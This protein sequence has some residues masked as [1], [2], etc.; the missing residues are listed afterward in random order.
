MPVF[1]L[2]IPQ[3]KQD[4]QKAKLWQ[5]SYLQQGVKQ[6]EAESKGHVYSAFKFYL[7]QHIFQNV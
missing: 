4:R 2:G 3:Q 7:E 5:F 1:S 6:G